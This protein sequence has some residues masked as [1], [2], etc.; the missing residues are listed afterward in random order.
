[1]RWRRDGERRQDAVCWAG[2]R[3][4]KTGGGVAGWVPRGVQAGMATRRENAREKAQREGRL[5]HAG[6]RSMAAGQDAGLIDGGA[7]RDGMGVACVGRFPE[8]KG[9]LW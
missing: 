9:G 3:L 2:I 7:A 6:K 1:M 4:D 5:D 8:G